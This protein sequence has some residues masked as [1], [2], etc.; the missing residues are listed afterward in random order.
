MLDRLHIWRGI[1]YTQDTHEVPINTRSIT[2]NE[3]ITVL[4]LP[5]AKDYYKT[6]FVKETWHYSHNNNNHKAGA[7]IFA[8]QKEIVEHLYST[9]CT[10]LDAVAGVIDVFINDE[11]YVCS[12]GL[13]DN[14][15]IQA[16]GA[17]KS[18]QHYFSSGR[19]IKYLNN[20]SVK[21]EQGKELIQDILNKELLVK[22][23]PTYILLELSVM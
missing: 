5:D 7:Y 6:S 15:L 17:K 11:R 12:Y 10:K 4:Y 22:R 9:A 16:I 14:L 2:K 13:L 18:I 23:L 8:V 19:S 1:L 21:D 20:Y 3:I